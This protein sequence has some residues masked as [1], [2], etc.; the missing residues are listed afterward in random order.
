[1]NPGASLK[2]SKTWQEFLTRDGILD[3]S[4]FLK[5]VIYEVLRIEASSTISSDFCLTETCTIYDKIFRSDSHIFIA[6]HRLHH[7][8]EVW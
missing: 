8:P 3:D 7:N 5:Q 6:I 4:P 2:D 1:M